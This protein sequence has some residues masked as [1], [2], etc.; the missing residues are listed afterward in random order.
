MQQELKKYDTVF[1][2]TI[3]H[4]TVQSLQSRQTNKEQSKVTSKVCLTWWQVREK[5]ARDEVGEW[6]WGV[7]FYGGGP[8]KP[9]Y[10]GGMWRR[11]GAWRADNWEP[12]VPGGEEADPRWLI[13][14]SKVKG[15]KGGGNGEAT[16]GQVG[17]HVAGGC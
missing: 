17:Q 9:H 2:Q 6:W 5:R 11:L 14:L 12:T 16:G 7:P 15:A 10:E 13:G 3:Q 8:G 4:L 1:L